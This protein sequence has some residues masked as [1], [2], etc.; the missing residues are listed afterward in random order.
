MGR[1]DAAQPFQFLFSAQASAPASYAFPEISPIDL[2]SRSMKSVKRFFSGGGGANDEPFEGSPPKKLRRQR[3][4]TT[5]DTINTPNPMFV[6]ED[7]FFTSP[8]RS[9][10]N[11]IVFENIT[12]VAQNMPIRSNSLP[13][14][15]R[16]A[17]NLADIDFSKPPQEWFNKD[18]APIN[19]GRRQFQSAEMPLPAESN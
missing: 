11:G 4:P 9:R 8:H 15:R 12:L 6:S 14:R 10:R 1:K 16:V 2:I 3:K 5:M 13:S 17:I 18:L 7:D 19:T